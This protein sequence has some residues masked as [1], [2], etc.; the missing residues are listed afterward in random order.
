MIVW[1]A[2]LPAEYRPRGGF[3]CQQVYDPALAFI[4][5][6]PPMTTTADITEAGYRPSFSANPHGVY[7]RERAREG[8]CGL[9]YSR[10][11][12]SLAAGHR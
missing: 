5:H 3:F 9:P 12:N 2:L 8:G 7:E 4:P 6:C 11:A 10:S 1:P